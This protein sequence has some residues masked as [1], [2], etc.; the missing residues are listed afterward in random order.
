MSQFQYCFQK[1]LKPK[2]LT[3]RQLVDEMV[4]NLFKRGSINSEDLLK[5]LDMLQ[6][7]L[8]HV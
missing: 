4:N 6:E 3:L 5:V 7:I 1:F 2:P 8:G